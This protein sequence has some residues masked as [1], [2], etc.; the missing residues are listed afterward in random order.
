M[1][2]G[3]KRILPNFRRPKNTRRIKHFEGFLF[4]PLLILKKIMKLIIQILKPKQ[5]VSSVCVF[6]CMGGEL[7]NNDLMPYDKFSQCCEN[8]L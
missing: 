5:T 3:E 6:I 4:L 8:E 2:G 7:N 1:E